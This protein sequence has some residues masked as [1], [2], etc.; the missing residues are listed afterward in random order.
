M[1]TSLLERLNSVLA[2][3]PAHTTIMLRWNCQQVLDALGDARATPLLDQLH[4][5]V[6][7]RAAEMTDLADR[8]R[9]IQATPTFR[10]IVAAHGRCGEPVA[11]D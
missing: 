11:P 6:Q 8:D 4:A 9:L 1:V 5:D 2:P 7:A 3:A 10:A